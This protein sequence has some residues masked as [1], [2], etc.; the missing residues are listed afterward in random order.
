M[1]AAYRDYRR[2]GEL[3]T[4]VSGVE[5]LKPQLALLFGSVA[6]GEFTQRSDIDVLAVFDRPMDCLDVYRNEST[7]VRDLK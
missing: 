1:K 6:T 3:M 5:A 4:F 7:V 2:L